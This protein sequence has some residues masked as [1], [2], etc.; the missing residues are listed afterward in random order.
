MT[1][2]S[3]LCCIH[4]TAEE[5]DTLFVREIQLTEVVVQSVKHDGQLRA[6]PVAAST[7]DR[8]TLQSR[9]V[10]GI[11]DISSLIPNLFIPDYGSKLTSPVYIRG[12]GSK[13][14]APSVGLYV[15]GIP[16]FE[17]SAFDFDLNEIEYIEIL[18]GPQGT[19]YGR[20]TMG[21]IINVY[22]RS[23]LRYRE[24]S[25]SA[26]V[27]DHSNLNANLAHYGTLTPQ[28]GYALSGNYIHSGGYFTN[29]YT[30]KKADELDAGSARTRLEWKINPALMLKLTHTSDYS[31]QGGY[32]YAPVDP[33]TGQTGT[34]NYND[35]SS[36]R[37]LLSS[38]GMS[39]TY[40][41]GAFSLNSQTAFQYLSDRQ[42]IDQDF[43]PAD[44]YFAI[45]NQQ[46]STFS[47]EIN[48]KSTAD[49]R[50]YKWL[51]GAFAF[52]QQVDN[53][54][55]L[56]Y[57]AQQYHTRKLYDIPTS[58][59]S[60]YHQSV[61]NNLLTERLSLTL[62][63]RYDS[64]T[65]TGDYVAYR[66]TAARSEQTAA[67]DS[68]LHFSQLT[69]KAAL[70]YN[71]PGE[72]MLYASAGKGYKTGGFNSSFYTD[73]ERVFEPEH[74]WNY[75]LG[76]KGPFFQNRLR[77]ELC[78]FYIDWRNQQIAQRLPDGKGS[79]LK[80]AGR[81]ES[82]GIEAT[83]YGNP[84]NG[85]TLSANWGYTRA[86]FKAYRQSET[87]D[88]AGKYLPMAPLHTFASEASY[89][90]PL[91]TASVEQ[92]VLNLHY[93][94]AGRLYWNEDNRVAQPFYGQLNGRIALTKGI[95]TFALWGKN[96]T[97]TEYTAFYFES[98][99]TG[100]A[101]KGRPF[102]AGASLTVII[103]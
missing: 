97:N 93:T 91:F 33:L 72:R 50:R 99:G 79:A 58:G 73:D 12:I 5:E 85:L 13:I 43:S 2:A 90:I 83:L 103:E 40:A 70:Q 52:H 88:Y 36:Y 54:V 9:N 60:F 57:K 49:G 3:L 89:R 17:K 46:Q 30:G 48:I 25:L 34:V 11:K 53:E 20:N 18:R 81:S 77:A 78:L 24:T 95:T 84:F 68:R 28:I 8:R 98:M 51:F 23:P 7:I 80:N 94:A 14:N 38:S 10:T 102:T 32:P 37:R 56:H 100:F 86:V 16:Y 29:R 55:I 82:R 31:T 66:N 63:L 61:L 44:T 65:A 87:V 22:T 15:D 4:I 62:G 64:E 71:L 45:Q 74:S 92:I 26:S 69:P 76:I 42:G 41:P 39:L 21:G 47:Q 75:E 67:F 96:M 19:L 101:Q 1:L 6:H 35:R 59:L 27:A